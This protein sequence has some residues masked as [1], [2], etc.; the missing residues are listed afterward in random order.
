MKSVSAISSY[1][2]NNDKSSG[3]AFAY[4]VKHLIASEKLPVSNLGVISV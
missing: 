2:K 1:E 4:I 3:K